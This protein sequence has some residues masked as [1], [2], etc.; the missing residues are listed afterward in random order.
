[1]GLRDL[2]R[3]SF[4]SLS[5]LLV[6][7]EVQKKKKDTIRSLSLL[8]GPEGG[9]SGDEVDQ[10]KQLGFSQ[11]QLGHRRLRSETAAITLITLT[12]D[13]LGEI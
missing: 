12:L 8:I 7:P 3:R 13:A 2:D 11:V 5:S 1:M 10:F 4:I 9:F 6:I